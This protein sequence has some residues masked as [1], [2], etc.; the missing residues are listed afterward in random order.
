MHTYQFIAMRCD[1]H[2]ETRT[3]PNVHTHTHTQFTIT[4][5]TYY[6]PTPT[7]IPVQN[8]NNFFTID[9]NHILTFSFEYKT[10][11]VLLNQ[12]LRNVQGNRCLFARVRRVQ[13]ICSAHRDVYE[14]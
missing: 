13:C 6:T 7:Q 10:L 8:T 14:T 5:N 4:T 11:F 1:L 9:N 3:I 12:I 2:I